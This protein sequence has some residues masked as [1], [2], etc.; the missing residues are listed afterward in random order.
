MFIA[1]QTYRYQPSG[2]VRHLDS[3]KLLWYP[4]V[5]GLTVYRNVCMISSENTEGHINVQG[6]GLRYFTLS[7]ARDETRSSSSV[8]FQY[9][10]FII[11]I[12][13]PHQYRGKAETESMTKSRTWMILIWQMWCQVFPTHF[14]FASSTAPLPWHQH[15]HLSYHGRC[16]R[17]C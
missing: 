16:H 14:S 10:G 11:K 1:S 6:D 12:C 2:T 7:S 15:H 4:A 13:D 3:T 17:Q 5:H 9:L 8:A